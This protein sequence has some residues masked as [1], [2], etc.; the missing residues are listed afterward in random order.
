MKLSRDYHL[1]VLVNFKS[2]SMLLQCI[3]IRTECMPVLFC[4]VKQKVIL[5][6]NNNYCRPGTH[7]HFIG[8]EG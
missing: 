4:L 6:S 8:L 3:D 2:N 7:Q 1:T 5:L